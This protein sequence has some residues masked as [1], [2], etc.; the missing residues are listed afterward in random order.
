[1]ASPPPSYGDTPPL[2]SY[3]R[4]FTAPSRALSLHERAGLDKSDADADLLY[5]HP[6][7]RIIAFS[8]PRESIP[9]QSKETLPDAD[10]P[11]D[12]VET[13]PWRSRS[14]IL[15][16]TGPIVIEK[17]RGSSYFLKSADQKVIHTIMRNS[18]CW[19]VDGESKFVLRIGK[20]RYYRIE[21]P[22]ETEEDKKKVEELKAAL[23]KVLRFER[24]PCPF[25]RAFHVDLPEDAITPRRKGTW[26]RRQQP[27][28]ATPSTDPL[29]VGRTK[30]SR[31][32]S[33]QGQNGLRSVQTYGRRGSDYGYSPSPSSSR[34]RPGADG[35]RSSTPSSVASGEDPRERRHDDESSE[36]GSQHEEEPEEVLPRRGLV[37]TT[38]DASRSRRSSIVETEQADP[39]LSV[40]EVEASRIKELE[41]AS[42]AQPAHSS[43]A[44]AETEAI[45]EMTPMSVQAQ[46]ADV[47]NIS[48][49]TNAPEPA[50]ENLET[51]AP[52]ENICPAVRHAEGQPAEHHEDEKAASEISE[53]AAAT[54]TSTETESEPILSQ[55]IEPSADDAGVETMI[56]PPSIGDIGDSEISS[57]LH[58]GAD[59]DAHEAAAGAPKEGTLSRVS[60]VDSFHTTDSLAQEPLSEDVQIID[61]EQRPQP[62][63][64][65]PF[66]LNRH[67]HQRGLS[68]LT[69]TASTVESEQSP[70]KRPS[71]GDS[72]DKVSTPGLA[73]SSMSDSSWPEVHTPPT[74]PIKDG[75]RRRLH[76]KRSF[77][78]LPPSTTLLSPSSSQTNYGS[79]FTADF[80]QKAANVAFVKPIEAVV[81]LVHILARIAGGATVSD[82]LSGELFRRPET[83]RRRTSFPDQPSAPRDDSEEEDDFG[84]PIRGRTKSQDPGMKPAAANTVATKED[85]ADSIFDLD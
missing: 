4:S 48:G 60:S 39:N 68:E 63:G 23:P 28:P 15:A 37:R 3:R 64:F 20:F 9:T 82:L 33:F 17:V 29:P 80:L 11:I 41:D 57:S 83:H 58:R 84:V 45:I 55:A 7:A 40:S 6:S 16:A 19:C 62:E 30:T 8:P 61:F 44:G 71:T 76:A 36:D 72:M 47:E 5:S 74:S 42:L 78:P 38:V 26:K 77:S 56:E 51:E 10:Y 67:Q 12:A 70:I 85:D 14:E 31:A 21:L 22:S 69:V 54:S 43:P 13:L 18:Q 59:L 46:E 35:Y 25:K 49:E 75:L 81:L 34:S 27:E 53:E 79:P 66:F 24:T 2:Q 50:E 1:M 32:W 65:T 73:Q 52:Q